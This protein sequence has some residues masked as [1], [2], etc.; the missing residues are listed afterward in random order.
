MLGKGLGRF[1]VMLFGMSRMGVRQNVMMRGLRVIAR[2]Q[3][4]GG[5]VV[6]VRG[7][8]VVLGGGCVMFSGFFGVR[9]R[10]APVISA[11]SALR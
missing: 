7:V 4:L 5:F 9:H 8:L 6:M 10:F 3:V 11:R 2:F 1:D